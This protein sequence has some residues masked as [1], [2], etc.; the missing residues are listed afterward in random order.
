MV[1]FISV[2]LDPGLIYGAVQ[3]H[4]GE[5]YGL[6]CAE[7]FDNKAA[8]VVCRESSFFNGMVLCCSAMGPS[9][10]PFTLS[11]V[12][13]KGSESSLKECSYNSNNPS[14]PSGQYASV[15]CPYYAGGFT[16]KLTVKIKKKISEQEIKLERS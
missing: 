12:Q 16:S 10:L 9:S 7:G 15:I 8:E 1:T 13:C 4:S 6:T 11:N 2:R 5:S 3:Y 14:C